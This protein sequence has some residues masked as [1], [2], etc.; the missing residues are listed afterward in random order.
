MSTH[1]AITDADMVALSDAV[2]DRLSGQFGDF[3]GTN[4]DWAVEA[5][6]DALARAGYAVVKRP[7]LR[8]TAEERDLLRAAL[9]RVVAVCVE[10]DMEAIMNGPGMVETAAIHRALMVEPAKEAEAQP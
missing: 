4:A 2:Y 10:A 8:A 9:M 1:E 6:I 5:T 3:N 7:E